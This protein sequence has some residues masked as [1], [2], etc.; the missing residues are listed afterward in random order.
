MDKRR[1]LI[2]DDN[3]EIHK[4]FHKILSQ[5]S[6]PQQDENELVLF[7]ETSTVN[8]HEVPVYLIDSAYQGKEALE[9]VKKALLEKQPYSLAFIDMR[10]PPGWD[11]IKTIKRIWEVD[12]Y[13]QMV[14]CS[15][16]SDNSWEDITDELGNSDNLLILKKPF[17]LIEIQQMASALTQKWEL[18]TN[19]QTLVKKRTSELEKSQSL[20]HATLESAQEGILAVGLDKNIL[21][22]NNNFLKLWDI[23]E[24]YVKSGNSEKL[25]D[26]LAERLEAPVL[27]LKIVDDLSARPKIMESREWILKSGTV[28]NIYAHPQYLHDEITGI[29]FSFSDI[30]ERKILEQQLMH[31]A[32]HDNLTGLP[33]R[34]LLLDRIEQAMANAKRYNQQVAVLVID[35]DRFKELNDSL[36]HSTGDALLKCHAQRLSEFFRKNDTISRIGG[37][38]FVGVLAAQA[39]DNNF[40]G[41]LNKLTDLFLKPCDING[42]EVVVTAS[43]G[44]S[45]FPED[46]EDAETL[47]K[48]AD[49]ALYHAKDLG[50]NQFQFYRE[51]FNKKILQRTELKKA[52]N[53]ALEND[54]LTLNYQPLV[55]LKSGSIIGTEALLRWNHPG[56]G[57]IPPDTFIPIAEETGLIYDIGEWVL[58]TACAKTLYWQES[59]AFP[60][61]KISVNISVKQ[62]RQKNFIA[63]VTDVLEETKLQPEFLEL[64]ITEGLILENISEV[65]EKMLELKKMGVHF[66]IDDF[67]MGYSSLSYIKHF[68]FDTIKIDK[69]F[70]DNITTDANNAS[71]VEAI[72]GMT[73]SLGINV[74]A[75]G[76]EHE[77]QVKFLK[78]HHSNQVQGYYFS[79]PLDDKEL[80]KMLK[81][82]KP[83]IP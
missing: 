10:M 65:I 71:I 60:K 33:N 27:F 73:K 55:D 68:P 34:V 54:E 67:G 32:T 31:Q 61:L 16:Y 64:E 5:N 1:I 15:A 36:G 9:A 12:P 77:E 81:K 63:L 66:A 35:L 56:I 37:D 6:E 20:T 23:P 82:I 50:Q 17:E 38:E 44:V 70:I 80:I 53:K 76:V 28:L 43:I 72:I 29:V 25:F 7:G 26:K 11:G 22:Y 40:V 14:I 49:A 74:L 75:E 8:Q 4:V 2:V 51:E 47:I 57:C 30:T 18:I 46:S 24:S 52:L 41:L 78:D 48:N 13:V 83:V 59:S 39:H 19:L 58:R 21:L 3:V 79:K 42:H 45:I 62:F 69:I